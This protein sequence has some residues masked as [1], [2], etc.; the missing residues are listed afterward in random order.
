MDTIQATQKASTNELADALR[1]AQNLKT[2]NG[3]LEK[4]ILVLKD[5]KEDVAAKLK[6]I[7]R[8]QESTDLRAKKQRMMKQRL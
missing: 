1:Q 7:K 6:I 4:Q 8:E 5:E 3:E 2:E